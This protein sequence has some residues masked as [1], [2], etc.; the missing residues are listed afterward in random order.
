MA[1]IAKPQGYALWSSSVG[2]KIT[3][4][5]SGIILY[6]FVIVHMLGNLKV[7][8]GRAAFNH[9]AEGLRTFGDPFF[10]RGQLLWILRIALLAALLVHLAAMLQL[11][12]QS[13]RA[14]R[15]GYKKFDG[16]E[17]SWASRTML[18]GGV[19]VLVY[20]VYHLLHM[21]FG[22]VH[23]NFVH[24]DAYNNFVIGFQDP[25]ASAAYIAAMIP[26]GL[27]MY[28]GFWSMLQTLGA[29]NPK[30]NR[31]R[32]PIALTLALIVVL[33]NISFPVAVLLGLV[34]L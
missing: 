13:R 6:G 16:L 8:Q 34:T 25:V 33:L 3:M 17:F 1:T 7:Y 23:P 4:A 9:Y 12:L 24:G 14:R 15:H 10:G 5:V 32:R 27:H 28:H 11:T 19:L 30:Y 26:L 18:W 20:V 21:T 2:K 31:V 29:N 22:T